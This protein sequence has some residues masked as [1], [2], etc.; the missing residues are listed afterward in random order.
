[1]IR[2]WN[3]PSFDESEHQPII[4]VDDDK[5]TVACVHA[6]IYKTYTPLKHYYEYPVIGPN[7]MSR[8]END[9]AT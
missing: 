4:F 5:Y 8:W 6:P 1:M 3:D 2:W 9:D 7:E